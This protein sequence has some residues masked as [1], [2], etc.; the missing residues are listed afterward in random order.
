M[1]QLTLNNGI[2]M[3]MLGLGVYQM[4]NHVECEQAVLTAIEAG[5]RLLLTGTRIRRLPLDMDTL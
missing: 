2:A 5:Y 4:I 1:R 3:P